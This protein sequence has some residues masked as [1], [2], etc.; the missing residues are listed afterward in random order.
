VVSGD[1]IFFK[2]AFGD[3][4]REFETM[5]LRPHR[6]IFNRDWYE[7]HEGRAEFEEY[8]VASRKVSDIDRAEMLA[9]VSSCEPREFANLAKSTQNRNLR[10]VLEFYKPISKS[11]EARIWTAQKMNIRGEDLTVMVPDD[12]RV[13]DAGL[14]DDSFAAR[15]RPTSFKSLRKA[16]MVT[17]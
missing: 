1:P 2:R 12:E 17:A 8:L 3:T 10:K 7:K 9:L 15:P 13:E 14:Q 4:V 11:E 16:Q 6:Y 5:L